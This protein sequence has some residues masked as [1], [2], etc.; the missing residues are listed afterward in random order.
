MDLNSARPP[1]GGVTG[2]DIRRHQDSLFSEH[3]IQIQLQVALQPN[4]CVTS[5]LKAPSLPHLYQVFT[6]Q[7]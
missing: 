6:G 7:Q 3:H 4:L 2:G 5:P 1:E